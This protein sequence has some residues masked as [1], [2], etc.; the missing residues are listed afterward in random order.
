MFSFYYTGL[1]FFPLFSHRTHARH[2]HLSRKS[3]CQSLQPCHCTGKLLFLFYFPSHSEQWRFIVFLFFH[4]FLSCTSCRSHLGM[5]VLIVFFLFYTGQKPSPMLH[6]SLEVWASHWLIV[7]FLFFAS[8]LFS[9]FPSFSTS[10]DEQNW[11][12]VVSLF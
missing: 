10:G 1:L 6:L 3:L 12:I 9:G 7:V 11:F 8:L 4:S 5:C 2:R